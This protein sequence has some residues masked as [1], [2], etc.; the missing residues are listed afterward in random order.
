MSTRLCL[1]GFGEV[2]VMLADGLAA[3][4]AI[5][6]YDPAFSDPSSRPRR[7]LEERSILGA[8]SAAEAARDADLII[9]AVTAAQT[10][11]AAESVCSTLKRGAYFLDLN[12]ASPAAKQ[13]AAAAI[14]AAGG[15]YV[16]A[17]VMAPV[18]P[19]HLG[20]PILLGGPHA[21]TF[22]PMALA[23]GFSAA[24]V[25][26]PDVGRAAAAKLCRSIVVKG[27][28]ALLLESLLSAR[29]YGVEDDVIASLSN[30]FPGPDWRALSS[31]MMSRA[32]EHGVRRAEE[33]R[34]AAR[35]VADAGLTPLLSEAIAA[36]QDWAA[37]TF[38]G[39]AEADLN[40]LY[41]ALHGAKEQT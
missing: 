7:A 11:A 12:S 32:I 10:V 5:S 6:A 30:M 26:A 34:E 36:R 38:A 27:V 18:A 41:Q 2:G 21:E 23:F 15:R 35:T 33:M 29:H 19:K 25:Y 14:E 17:A 31:Y 13:D 22:A 4:G 1:I 16:E 20:T 37:E 3:H 8:A 24:R 39:L 40:T 9:S 28:E